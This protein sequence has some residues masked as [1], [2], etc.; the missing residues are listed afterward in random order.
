MIRV[1]LRVNGQNAT[2]RGVGVRESNALIPSDGGDIRYERF[3]LRGESAYIQ[4]RRDKSGWVRRGLPLASD[5]AAL[6]FTFTYDLLPRLP[7][8]V[9]AILPLPLLLLIRFLVGFRQFA[10]PGVQGFPQL[11]GDFRIPFNQIPVLGRIC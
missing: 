6:A 10:D 8:P 2:K 7:L 5:S 3:A 9:P 11:R 1:T 4:L